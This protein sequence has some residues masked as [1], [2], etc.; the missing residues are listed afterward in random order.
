ML[1]PLGA[2]EL[3]PNALP[4]DA[5]VVPKAARP[6]LR[7]AYLDGMRALAALYVVAFHSLLGF[8]RESLVGRYRFL[9]A[10]FGFG[11]E[12]VAVFIVLSGYCLMLPLVRERPEQL[13]PSFRAFVRRRALR[14]LPPYFAALVGS[15]L[16]IYALA[17]L[18]SGNTGTIWDDSLPALELGPILSH[19]LLVHNWA[20]EFTHRINGPLWSVATEWQIYFFFPLLL[21]PVWRRFGMA[22]ALG[23]AAF[24]G[25]GPLLFAPRA[26][27]SAVSWYLVLFTFG[28]SAAAVG[29]SSDE[30]RPLNAAWPWNVIAA[31]SWALC[32]GFALGAATIWFRFKPLSDVLVGFATAATLVYLTGRAAS[33]PRGVPLR[34]LESKPLVAI[35]HFSYS[36][37]LTHLPVV[38]LLWFALAPLRAS[39]LLAAWVLLG[40]STFASLGVAYVFHRAIERPSM[41]WR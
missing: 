40:V 39:P 2:G 8:S 41:A 23:A 5:P 25:Y 27:E 15:L 35:G 31:A 10:V 32:G 22:G 20:P 12:A 3:S 17:P 18:R 37:Y 33:E 26:A 36:L 28:M 7:L 1:E 34:L 30:R 14:I 6:R 29:F 38:A 19:V 9:R 21:L 16:V 13:A 24:F 11:H 4:A